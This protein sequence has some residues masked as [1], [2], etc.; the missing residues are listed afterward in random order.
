MSARKVAVTALLLNVALCVCEMSEGSQSLVR[1]QAQ[2]TTL[3]VECWDSGSWTKSH[4]PSYDQFV[5]SDYSSDDCTDSCQYEEHRRVCVKLAM[6][7]GASFTCC[8]P[9][10]AKS[11][12]I[13]LHVQTEGSSEGTV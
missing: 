2:G 3:G 7:G 8:P 11:R 12:G 1:R 6:S 9:S 4:C 10:A 5:C 13:M